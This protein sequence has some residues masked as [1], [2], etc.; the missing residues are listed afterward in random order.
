MRRWFRQLSIIMAITAAYFASSVTL[1]NSPPV[2]Q[3]SYE[4]CISE[5]FR[6][7]AVCTFGYALPDRAE[8]EA[9]CASLWEPENQ[10]R[11]PAN[12]S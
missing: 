4:D 8:R 9:K 1:H 11:R 5:Q 10:C 6:N 3:A 2:T 7:A 12:S